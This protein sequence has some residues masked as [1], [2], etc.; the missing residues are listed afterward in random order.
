[1][2]NYQKQFEFNIKI[3]K[4]VKYDLEKLGIE[5]DEAMEQLIIK[6]LKEHISKKNNTFTKEQLD[7]ILRDDLFSD[8]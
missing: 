6:L 7:A 3:E 8:N 1:M 4:N 5:S 2:S